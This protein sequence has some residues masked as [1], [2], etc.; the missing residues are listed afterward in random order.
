MQN[1]MTLVVQLAVGLVFLLSVA[2]KLINPR[3]FA[4]G[5]VKYQ[6]LPDRLSYVVG[7][8][9]IPTEVLLAAFHLTGRL[10]SFGALLGVGVL[11]CFAAGVAVNLKRGRSLPCYCFGNSKGDVISGR[12]LA[13]LTLLMVGEMLLLADLA[14]SRTD[15]PANLDRVHDVSEFSLAFLSAIFLLIFGS[16][17]LNAADVVELLRPWRNDGALSSQSASDSTQNIQH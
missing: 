11:A 17:L 5:V 16:W 2:G 4:R 6:V 13:R 3:D 1:R 12:T 14:L 9:L 7:L 10:L 8:T 15:N